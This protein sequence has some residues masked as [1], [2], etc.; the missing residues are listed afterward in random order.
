MENSRKGSTHPIGRCIFVFAGATSYTFDHFIREGDDIEWK[1]QKGPDFASRLQGYLNVLGPNPRQRWVPAEGKDRDR[2]EWKVDLTDICFPVRRAVL[3]R[4]WFG[5]VAEH[6]NDRLEMDASLL[7]ALL[8][9][10]QYQHGARSMERIVTRI[11]A[12][13]KPY[14]RSSLPPDDL[15]GLDVSLEDFREILS[16]SRDF[17]TAAEK[18]APSIHGFYLDLSHKEHWR[19]PYDM[20]YDQLPAPVKA[21]NIAAARRI[22]WILGLAGLYLIQVPEPQ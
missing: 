17:E 13:P 8:E 18:L 1:R 14:S 7:A 10:D 12:G 20:P 11:K 4:S 15:L 19:L 21:D 16:R 2:G 22:P 9:V 3:L 6:K 5:L